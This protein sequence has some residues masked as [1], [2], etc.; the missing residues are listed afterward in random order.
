M[1]EY[2]HLA[3]AEAAQES[4]LQD[5]FLVLDA[6]NK[7]C[8]ER[9]GTP[10]WPNVVASRKD[11]EDRLESGEVYVRRDVHGKVSSTVTVRETNREWGALAHDNQALYFTKYMK[12]SSRASGNEAKELLLFVAEE[13]H[14]RQK[15]VVRCDAVTDQVGILD[16]Y[17]NRLGFIERGHTIYGLTG[18]EGILLEVSAYTLEERIRGLR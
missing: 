4:D 7:L 1:S 15:P 6:A 16:Y 10:D 3:K 18:R 5:L 8:I 11:I 12:D 9:S 14:R 17:Q 2:S 13:A